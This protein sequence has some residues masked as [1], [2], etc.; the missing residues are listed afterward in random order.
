MTMLKSHERIILEVVAASDGRRD[1]RRLDFDYYARSRDLLEPNIFRALRDL[2]KRGLV[3]PVQINGGTGPGWNL[4]SEGR[5]TLD[6]KDA[7][8]TESAPTRNNA[9]ETFGPE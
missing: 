2:E 3:T 9:R 5:R 6:D 1:T 7:S 8:S 4:T